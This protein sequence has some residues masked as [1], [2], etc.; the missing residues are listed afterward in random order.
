M[1]EVVVAVDLS[2]EADKEVFAKHLNTEGLS[3]LASEEMVF[4]GQTPTTYMQTKAFLMNVLAKAFWLSGSEHC[5]FVCQ[6]GPNTPNRF[7]SSKEKE[8][9]EVIL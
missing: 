9:F 6:I 3:L 1:M 7:K 5:N 4:V 2:K 8:M